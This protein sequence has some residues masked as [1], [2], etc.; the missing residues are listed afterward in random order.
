MA[1]LEIYPEGSAEEVSPNK[2]TDELSPEVPGR[3]SACGDS[4]R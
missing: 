3:S 1:A 2:A 4:W